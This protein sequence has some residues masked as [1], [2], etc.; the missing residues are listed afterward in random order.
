MADEVLSQAELETLLSSLESTTAR[1]VSDSGGHALPA[2]HTARF[3]DK[4]SGRSSE[5]AQ[6]QRLSQLELTALGSLHERVGRGF[7]V[8]VS[9]LLRTV[10]EVKLSWIEQVPYGDFVGRM[11]NPTCASVVRAA[12]LA[13]KW[14]LDANPNV[15]YAMI[16]R[17]LGG[18]REPGLIA[19]RPLTEIELRLASRVTKLFLRELEQA[20]QST[21]EL[22]LSV[23]RVESN[24]RLVLSVPSNE[25]VVLIGFETKIG[26]VRGAMNLCL[27]TASIAP[28]AAKLARAADKS[29]A[30]GTAEES[31]R[32]TEH[33]RAPAN[34][35]L[36]V[37]LADT[38]I[39]TR[40]LHHLRIGDI[41]ATDQTVGGPLAVTIEG[42]RVFYAHP[43]ATEGRKAVRIEEIHAPTADNKAAE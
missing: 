20:W 41:I 32:D 26:D 19:L 6:G 10:A 40:D 39:A 25:C 27:P 5:L 14:I 8:A 2:P 23:D 42:R 9:A 11:Q 17:L 22:S 13:A 16:D 36:V 28:W 33:D 21:G 18:G 34:V 1:R 30:S 7:S 4:N 37:H 24:P 31:L 29:T 3:K 43:G 35:E 15:L 38:Q 12:P